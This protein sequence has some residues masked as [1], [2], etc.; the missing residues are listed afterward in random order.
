VSLTGR[1]RP[2]ALPILSEARK[3]YCEMKG[4]GADKRFAGYTSRGVSYVVYQS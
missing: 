1:H 2:I 4:E 3:T